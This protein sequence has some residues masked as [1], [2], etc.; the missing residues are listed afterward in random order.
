[1]IDKPTKTGHRYMSPSEYPCLDGVPFSAGEDNGPYISPWLKR[2]A[3]I[4]AAIAMLGS[5]Y[6]TTK[7]SNPQT[8]TIASCPPEGLVNPVKYSP[9]F[10]CSVP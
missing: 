4:I 1:M 5:V 2:G 6:L 7:P 10:H 8:A 9:N 3:F